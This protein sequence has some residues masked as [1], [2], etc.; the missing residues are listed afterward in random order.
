MAR[1][2]SALSLQ[3]SVLLIPLGARGMQLLPKKTFTAAAD[4]RS[5][6]FAPLHFRP[7]SIVARGIFARQ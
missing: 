2:V 4:G 5:F 6:I 1:P 3:I 7:D